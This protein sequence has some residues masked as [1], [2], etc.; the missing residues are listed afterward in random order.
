MTSYAEGEPL[1]IVKIVEMI[2]E[3]P[4][5]WEDALHEVIVEAQKTLRGITRVAATDFDVRMKDDKIDVFR[6]RAEVS[7]RLESDSSPAFPMPCDESASR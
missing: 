6:V 5:S 2:G 4:H 1:P 7:F 3:S